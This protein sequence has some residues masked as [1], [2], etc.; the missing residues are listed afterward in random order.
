MLKK[1]WIGFLLLLLLFSCSSENKVFYVNSYHQGYPPSD[2]VFQA[3][4][5]VFDS[6][7]DIHLETYFLDSKLNPSPEKIQ[8]NVALALEQIQKFKPDLIIASDDDAVKYLV[9]PYLK[10]T[11][12]PVVFCGVNWSANQYGL[13][14]PNVTGMLEVLP[15]RENLQQIKKINPEARKMLILSENSTSEQNNRVLLDTLFRSAGFEPEYELVNEFADWKSAFVD[16]NETFDLIYLPTNGSIKNWNKDEAIETVRQN[17]RIPVFTCDDFMMPYCI[18]GM[19]KVASEQG[20]WAAKTALEI[21]YGKN[22]TEIPLAINKRSKTFFNSELAVR[23]TATFHGSKEVGKGLESK[24]R[25]EMGLNSINYP[26]FLDGPF[27]IEYKFDTESLLAYYSGI[28]S[29]AGMERITG[30]N[31]KQLWSYL[32]G[33]SKPRKAQVQRIEKAIHTLG[34]EL[35]TVSL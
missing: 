34:A 21:L 33:H 27:E 30:I 12:T 26:S 22:I 24:I 29:L 19:T 25:K 16:A 1:I 31:R 28:L 2:E 11:K 20:E 10:G 14:A 5:N 4:K 8:Q 13:P 3:I 15:L 18:F 32:H 23:Y 35:S 6:A 17:I 9:V 7:Q